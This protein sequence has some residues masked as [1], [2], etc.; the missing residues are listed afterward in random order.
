VRSRQQPPEPHCTSA[1]TI[2]TPGGTAWAARL[3]GTEPSS[4]PSRS[5]GTTTQSV[6][7]TRT[8]TA[9]RISVLRRIRAPYRQLVPP[10]SVVAGLACG[11]S[12]VEQARL[13]RG[14]HPSAGR[15]AGSGRPR[16]YRS[17][18]PGRPG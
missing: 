8:S 9:L 7:R 10:R 14:T 6:T 15:R 2:S 3:D 13:P 11:R 4:T 17:P 18:S 5:R 16:R 12:L 1:E